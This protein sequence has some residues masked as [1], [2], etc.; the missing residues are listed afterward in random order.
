MSR[1]VA[2]ILLALCS[3]LLVSGHGLSRKLQED[4][5]RKETEWVE[6]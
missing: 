4:L 5:G 2:A 3:L 6:S 1:R